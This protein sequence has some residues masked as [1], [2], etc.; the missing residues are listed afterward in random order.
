[1][2]QYNRLLGRIADEFHIC[3]GKKEADEC[4]KARVVYSLLGRMG[5]ASLWDIRED[6]EPISV[7]H[8]K[9][10]IESVLESYLEMYPELC[11]FFPQ[12]VSELSTEIYN[13]FLDTGQM[14]HSSYRL[15]PAAKSVSEKNGIYFMRGMPLNRKQYISGIGSYSFLE[16]EPDVIKSEDMFQLQKNTL[17]EQWEYSVSHA[18]WYPLD[19]KSGIEYLCIKPPST[20]NYWIEKPNILGTVSLARI[21]LP[22]NKIYYL[23]KVE[24]GKL[25]GSQLPRWMGIDNHYR[26]LSN[27][28]LA[29]VGNLPASTYHVDG[30]VVQLRIH[31]LLPPKELNLIKLYS[32]PESFVDLPDDFFRIFD[33]Q[34]FFAVKSI[35]EPI[36]YT[37]IEE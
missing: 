15:A 1:M 30:N 37:F 16:D 17:V 11:L 31:Y 14:Y 35:L 4:W 26:V 6:F 19:A 20:Y 21:G 12:S 27:A 24:S 5:Y 18:K 8:F 34:V 25:L 3:Q 10:R 36:G 22:G 32:W 13:I 9:N 28:C 29:S 2:N 33:I 23:Y 7:V